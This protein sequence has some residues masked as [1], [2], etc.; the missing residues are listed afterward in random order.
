VLSRLADRIN[1]E[2][3]LKSTKAQWEQLE[4]ISDL[5]KFSAGMVVSLRMALNL[6][7][8]ECSWFMDPTKSNTTPEI[9]AQMDQLFSG[10]R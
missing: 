1:D 10:I 5:V 8:I 4:K 2:L 3:L 9:F 6:A 7:P